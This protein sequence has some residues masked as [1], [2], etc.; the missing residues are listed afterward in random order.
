VACPCDPVDIIDVTHFSI[1]FLH[2]P[3]DFVFTLAENLARLENFLIVRRSR[4]KKEKEKQKKNKRQI[5]KTKLYFWFL[6]LRDLRK[7]RKFSIFATFSAS[8]NTKQVDH[9]ESKCKIE[10]HRQ[11][12][13]DHM[14]TP[15]KSAK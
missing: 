5:K 13:P 11:F 10:L 15:P 4:R 14:D 6:L 9:V 2:D 1:Y 3:L 8:V 7:I 12:Q